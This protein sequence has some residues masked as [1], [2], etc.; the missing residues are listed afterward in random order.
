MIALL[1]RD[2]LCLATGN[3][4]DQIYTIQACIPLATIK[5]EAADNGRGN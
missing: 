3:R 2:W 4:V 5:V 1:Y